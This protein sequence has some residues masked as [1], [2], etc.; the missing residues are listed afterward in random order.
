MSRWSR[1]LAKVKEYHFELRHVLVLFVILA[2]AQILISLVQKYSIQEFLVRTQESYQED[3]AERLANLTATSLEL[4]LETASETRIQGQSNKKKMIEAFNIIF[5]QQLLSHDVEEVCLLVSTGDSVFA[6]D[7]G[8]VLYDYF[9]ENAIHLPRPDSP[10]AFGIHLYSKLRKAIHDS[11]QIQSHLEGRQTFHVLVPF[12][13][14]GEVSGA[15]YMKN[16]PDFAFITN[17]I[18]TSYNE[19]NLIFTGL[20]LFGLLAMFYI[21][22]YTLRERDETQELLFQERE[23]QLEERIHH[24]KES[25]FTKRIYHSHHKAEKVMG[26]IKEDLRNLSLE[27]IETIK[28]RVTKYANFVSRVIYD[29]KWF[30]PPIQTIRNPM[31]RTDLNEVIQFIVKNICLRKSEESSSYQFRLDL[32]DALPPVAVNE[33][34]IWEI[35][36]PLFQN[37]MDHNEQGGITIGVVTRHCTNEKKSQ[38]IL[39]DDGQGIQPDLLLKDE[40]GVKKIFQEHISTKAHEKSSGYG[41]YLAYEI[42]KERCGWDLDARNLKAGGC[43][44]TITIHH[45]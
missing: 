36:E 19:T 7:N 34:V 27:N 29:M 5:T 20:I 3:S 23:R 15:L 13:P 10:H 26:F 14:K 11:E 32:D 31:F 40:N 6:I 44:F 16:S 43:E 9:F 41:C 45:Y 21:S 39:S 17:E 22:S 42:A 38:I 30:E 24:Q 1:F 33:F 4:L 18:L 25:L 8:R 12:V 35:L 28:H 2:A 37:S